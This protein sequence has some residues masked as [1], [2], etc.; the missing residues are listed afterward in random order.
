MTGG[1]CASIELLQG[2]SVARNELWESRGE[3]S[4]S[5]GKGKSRKL[6]WYKYG[7][8]SSFDRCGKLKVEGSGFYD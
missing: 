8:T 5:R 2:E 6:R 1:F 4:Y 3:A 7:V